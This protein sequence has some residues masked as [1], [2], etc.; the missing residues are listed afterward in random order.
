MNEISFEKKVNNLFNAE[1]IEKKWEIIKELILKTIDRNVLKKS[2][3]Q[4]DMKWM[5]DEEKQMFEERKKD[6][7]NTE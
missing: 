7:R 4:K 3:K 1:N 2:A 5:T 6:H